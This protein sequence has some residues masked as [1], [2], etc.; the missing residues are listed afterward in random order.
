VGLV[1]LLGPHPEHLPALPGQGL[2]LVALDHKKILTGDV[3]DWLTSV[4]R[5]CLAMF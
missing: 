4:L 2:G 1:P 3:Q 5:C